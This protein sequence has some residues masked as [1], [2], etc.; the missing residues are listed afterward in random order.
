M[1][2]HYAWRRIKSGGM[3]WYGRPHVLLCIVCCSLYPGM[4]DH[5]YFYVHM[6]FGLNGLLASGIALLGT[7]VSGSVWGGVL[8]VTTFFYN[9]GQST[10]VMWTPPLRESFAMPLLFL[11]TLILSFIIRKR[12]CS[13]VVWTSLVLAT[14]A[15]LLPWQFS[16]FTLL[17]QVLSVLVVHCLRLISSQKFLRILL[18]YTL[19][20]AVNVVLQFGNNMLLTSFLPSCLLS[21]LIVGL[22]SSTSHL[23]KF[24]PLIMVVEVS[25]VIVGSV[26]MKMGVAAILG[27][28]EDEHIISILL[29]KFTSY[30]DFHTQLYTCAAEFDFL[31][32]SY[33]LDLTWTLLLPMSVVSM[34]IITVRVV[35]H[36]FGKEETGHSDDVMATPPGDL[37][38]QVYHLMQ[39][40]AYVVMATLIMRLKLFLSPQLAVV[41]GLLPS[42]LR[43]SG[44][45]RS[46]YKWMVAGLLVCSSLKGWHNFHLQ[47]SV[48]GEYNNPEG[49]QLALWIRDHT[50]ETAVFAG[51]MPTM[52]TVLLTTGRPIV[53]HPHYETASLRNRTYHVYSIFG[54]KPVKE[55]HSIL[56]GMGADYV[57]SEDG[58]CHKHRSKPG[59]S[60][61]EMWDEEDPVNKERPVFCA[62]LQ[63][64]TPSPFQ[65]VYHN[66]VYRV[67]RVANGNDKSDSH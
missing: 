21:C 8:S 62:V 48:I 39:T 29:S 49:E 35:K 25:V 23:L 60:F 3:Q 30:H 59:C 65:L 19:A 15:F 34:A 18:A 26:L 50:P 10:R 41:A 40:V 37:A 5:M 67:L 52:A 2:L 22:L 44:L 42:L 13:L 56:H 33:V 53:N 66:P 54:R 12:S 36:I 16:Q 1:L 24:R 51:T 61:S 7:F 20:F 31:P 57:I 17:T 47:H 32:L 14:V 58:W 28:K 27:A 11:Q 55:I 63:T 9:H 4:G 45:S 46:Q 43:A 38:V 6:I 64:H